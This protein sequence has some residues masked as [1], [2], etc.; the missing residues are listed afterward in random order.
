MLAQLD[1]GRTL[2]VGVSACAGVLGPSLG[3]TASAV[4][5]D[6]ARGAGAVVSALFS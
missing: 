5:E 6:F 1:P 4:V 3:V 2:L